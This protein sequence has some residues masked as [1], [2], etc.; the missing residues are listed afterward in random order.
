MR[1]LSIPALQAALD[2]ESNK[3]I[4]SFGKPIGQERVSMP[5]DGIKLN[6]NITLINYLERIAKSNETHT[7]TGTFY[8]NREQYE[9][10][11]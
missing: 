9:I 5:E 6:E 8:L 4:A 2:H 3:I 11:K 7:S 10:S 1:R